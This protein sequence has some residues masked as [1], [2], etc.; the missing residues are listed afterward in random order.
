LERKSHLI[1]IEILFEDFFGGNA[2]KGKSLK[3]KGLFKNYVTVNSRVNFVIR[4][5]KV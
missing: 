5:L 2:M 4:K 3:Q 1:S